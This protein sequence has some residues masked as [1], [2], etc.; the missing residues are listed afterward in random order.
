MVEAR[1]LASQL[2]KAIET[3]RAQQEHLGANLEA[4]LQILRRDPNYQEATVLI[5]ALLRNSNSADVIQHL[6]T[7][8]RAFL[9]GFLIHHD[10]LKHLLD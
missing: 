4:D 5:E 1:E 3:A 8:N 2:D 7:V 10:E 9:G 6:K